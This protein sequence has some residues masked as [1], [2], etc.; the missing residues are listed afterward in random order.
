MKRAIFKIGRHCLISSQNETDRYEIDIPPVWF[1]Q[2]DNWTLPVTKSRKEKTEDGTAIL[3]GNINPG[4]KEQF[5]EDSVAFTSKLIGMIS[6]HYAF[7]IE[8]GFT[9]KVNGKSIP[10]FT[11]RYVFDRNLVNLAPTI[12]PFVFSTTTDD[13]VEVFLTVGFYRDLPT[14]AEIELENKQPQHSSEEAGWTVVCNDRAVV[15]CDKTILTGWGDS[16]VPRYHT[17]FIA[18]SGIVEFR[19][20]D[21]RKLPTTTTKRGLDASRPVYMQIKNK[22]REGMKIFTD[23]TNR[24]KG[25]E[26]ESKKQMQDLPQLSLSEIKIAITTLPLHATTRSLPLG[27][28]YMPELPKPKLLKPTQARISFVR[29]LEDIRMIAEYFE[30]PNKKSN[31]IGEACFDFVLDEAKK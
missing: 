1:D 14:N 15:Y 5:N 17:Q 19:A 8:K 4:I 25:R 28:Q 13:G 30:T 23:Y 7:I 21:P 12:R 9:V 22:M 16:G 27:Q 18:I 2:E 29:D 26:S 31:E 20:A 3:I 10:S 24:W 11:T 6:Q